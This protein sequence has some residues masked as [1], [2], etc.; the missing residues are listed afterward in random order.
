MD[1]LKQWIIKTILCFKSKYLFCIY[2]QS[3]FLTLFYLKWL[4]DPTVTED[5]R[6]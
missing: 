1:D 5:A 6:G 4:I 2:N 3:V